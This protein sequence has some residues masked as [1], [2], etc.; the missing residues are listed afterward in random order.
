MK[1]IALDFG[2]STLK[3]FSKDTVE[4][5]FSFP[6]VYST[7]I[8]KDGE[9]VKAYGMEAIKL[10]KFPNTRMVWPISK[11]SI[12][13]QERVA[14]HLI[15]IALERATGS[16]NFSDLH[17]L[18]ALPFKATGSEEATKLMA[19]LNKMDVGECS[20]WYQA[21]GIMRDSG[22]RT[23]IIVS[24]GQ[25]TTEVM[26]MLD[27]EIISEESLTKGADHILSILGKEKFLD[28]QY[29]AANKDKI[30]KEVAGFADEIASTIRKLRDDINTE[31]VPIVISGGGIMIPGM[32][33][34]LKKILGDSQYKFTVPDD[35]LYS[36]ARG[37]YSSVKD[38]EIPK[39]E[40]SLQEEIQPQEIEN[41]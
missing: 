1:T 28:H 24:I 31:D 22:I 34:E 40:T 20:I 16:K 12:G 30:A 33:D 23:G 13:G 19:L 36:T 5:K 3:V 7:R 17:V 29:I 2:T 26:S 15:R 9:T 21:H 27:D 18:L 25:G 14:E 38:A 41:R 6:S 8:N 35:P 39:T 37:L 32:H 10:N 4:T 11:G